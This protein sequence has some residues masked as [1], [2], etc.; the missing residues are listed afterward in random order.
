MRLRRRRK[1]QLVVYENARHRLCL[2]Q[3]DR[4]NRDLIAFIED[5]AVSTADRGRPVEPSARTSAVARGS[6]FGTSAA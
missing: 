3:G 2:T 4:L 5:D 6:G 1:S